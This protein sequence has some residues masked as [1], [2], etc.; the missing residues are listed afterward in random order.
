[1]TLGVSCWSYLNHVFSQCQHDTELSIDV[2]GSSGQ[3]HLLR[4]TSEHLDL[5]E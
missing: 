1:M 4:S 3:H 5:P 2:S